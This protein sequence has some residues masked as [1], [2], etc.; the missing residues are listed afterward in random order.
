MT[1]LLLAAG[2]VLAIGASLGDAVRRRAPLAWHAYVPWHALIFVGG[3]MILLAA[4]HLF[5][6]VDAST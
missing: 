1:I 4:V 6:L 5:K 3:V 2:A